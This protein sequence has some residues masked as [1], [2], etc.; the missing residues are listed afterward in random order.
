MSNSSLPEGEP[1]TAVT[2]LLAEPITPERLQQFADSH[3]FPLA[4]PGCVTFVWIGQT[5]QVTLLRWIHGGVDRASFKHVPDTPL[6]LLHLPVTDGGRFEYKLGVEENGHEEWVMDPLNKFKAGDPYGENSVCR[7]YGYSQPEWSKPQGATAGTIVAL[8]VASEIFQETR[9]EQVYLPANHDP[10]QAYPLLVIHD[11]ADFIT[12]ADLATSL[13]NL[14]AAGT[15]P[16]IIAALVQTR[17]RLGE[18]ARGH[19]H[20]RYLVHDLLPLLES[21]FTLSQRSEDRV[22]LG[23]SLGAVVGNGVSV[24]RCVWRRHFAIRLFHSG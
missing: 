6:W 12:Y 14:I 18:Y 21:R 5:S 16:P 1:H 2:Q 23:A 9:N 3:E 8:Q 13:D 20:A 17:D 7:T 15:I 22:L 19:H 4:A 10:T 24:S 11:G